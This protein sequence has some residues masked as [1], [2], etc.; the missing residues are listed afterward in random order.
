MATKKIIAWVDG[1]AQEIEV[2]DMT[3]PALAPNID[4][5]LE[6]LENS[7]PRI[8]EVTLLA[9]EWTGDTSPYSQIVEIDGVTEYSQVD[10]KPS[11]EQLDVFHN[12]DIGF[13]TEN[14]DG[15]VTVYL[16]G[17]KPDNDYT[18]QISI[19]EVNL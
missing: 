17:K 18:M 6:S 14:E 8:S 15:V 5:R 19:T 3:S 16:I 1:A 11:V 13:V 9:S 2:L 4:T 12:K 7:V 10:L